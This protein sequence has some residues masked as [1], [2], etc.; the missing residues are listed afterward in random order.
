MFNFIGN[1]F[2]DLHPIIVHFPI[3]LLMVSFLLTF[4]ARWQPQWHET[5]WLLLVLGGLATIPAT[6]TGMIAH[7][8]YEET[9]LI[10]FI[11]PHQFLGLLGTLF[12]IGVLI[13]RWRSRTSGNDAGQTTAYLVIA[14]IGIVW[15]FFLGGTGGNLVYEYAVNVRGVNP[16]LP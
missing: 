6:I 16:L 1:I 5:S 3:A 13:W 4:G 9:E 7:L 11:E 14:L 10:T 15:L 8:P 12:T 2:N